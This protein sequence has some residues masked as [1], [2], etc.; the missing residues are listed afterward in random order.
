MCIPPGRVRLASERSGWGRE[1]RDFTRAFSGAYIFGIPLLFTMEMWWIGEYIDRWK[2]VA[3]L[4][5]AFG[6]NIGL[7]WAAGFKREYSFKSA[8][9]QAIDVVAIGIIAAA[10]M[11][12][13]LNRINVHDPLDTI[14]GTV[15]IQ[16]VPLS[17]GAS[18]ANEVF[19]QRGG[20]GR[21]GDDEPSDI[22]PWKALF[23]DIGATMIGGIFIG[24]SIAPTEEV[25]KLAAGLSFGHLVAVVTFSLVV[26]YA[27]V[28][29]SEFDQPQP[30]GL[31]QRPITETTLAYVVS[32]LVSLVVLWLFDQVESGDPVR[33][34]IEQTIVL[35][36]P[37]TV[38]G[39]AGRLVV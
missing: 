5:V 28:F 27:I 10:T 12:L 1:L 39:A 22:S 3:F 13:I 37:T 21:Q 35:A 26:S 32:V 29:A 11:L 30:A 16:A 19:G 24:F 23:N 25:P 4:L 34:V 38:G 7:S 8:V 18:V 20:N 9:L 15:I 36:V 2:L 6:A 33:S 14:L 17:I 31:F